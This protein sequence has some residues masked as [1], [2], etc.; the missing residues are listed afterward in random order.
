MEVLTTI[1]LDWSEQ[2][3]WSLPLVQKGKSCAINL[4]LLSLL[5]IHTDPWWAHTIHMHT[6]I[7]LLTVTC[8][9]AQSLS[10]VGLFE[11]PRTSV[12]QA[13]LSMVL[14]SKQEYWSGLPCPS[15]ADLPD[16]GTNQHLLW[17]LHWHAD[18]LPLS[19]LRSPLVQLNM[20][21]KEEGSNRHQQPMETNG[22]S[23]W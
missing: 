3:E 13:P 5:Q 9:H 20:R 6:P 7:P 12:R 4:F 8:V 14:F 22:S 21:K 10:R 15:P 1:S 2:P 19:H 18:S 17:L 11:I 23:Q 16:P